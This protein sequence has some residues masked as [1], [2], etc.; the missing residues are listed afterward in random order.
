MSKFK[1]AVVGDDGIDSPMAE[2]ELHK[3]FHHFVGERPDIE[4]AFNKACL[5]YTSYIC[6]KDV[7]KFGCYTVK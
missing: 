6:N 4:P 3:I 2:D 5:L 7:T 1:Y